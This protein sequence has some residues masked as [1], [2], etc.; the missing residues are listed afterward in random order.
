MRVA[1]SMPMTGPGHRDRLGEADFGGIGDG[2]GLCLNDFFEAVLDEVAAQGHAIPRVFGVFV[3][4][5]LEDVPVAAEV[6]VSV[7]G[8]DEDPLDQ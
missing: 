7:D 4:H 1:I 6:L 5:L 3:D 8:E 2:C